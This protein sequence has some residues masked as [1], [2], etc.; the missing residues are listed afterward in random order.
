MVLITNV[1][2]NAL[3]YSWNNAKWQLKIYFL[4]KHP[5]T[6]VHNQITTTM[7]MCGASWWAHCTT[8]SSAALNRLCES[9]KSPDSVGPPLSLWIEDLADERAGAASLQPTYVY[10]RFD[11]HPMISNRARN[12]SVL[13]LVLPGAPPA[14]SQPNVHKHNNIKYIHKIRLVYNKP[15]NKR[16][17]SVQRSNRSEP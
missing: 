9:G 3:F 7:T 6:R 2:V 5:T 11:L 14:D 12:R 4:R 1:M 10:T 15:S 16:R 8:A 17:W 13:A